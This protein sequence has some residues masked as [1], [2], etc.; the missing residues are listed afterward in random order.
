M[1][2]EGLQNWGTRGPFESIRAGKRMRRPLDNV[3]EVIL[4]EKILPALTAGDKFQKMLQGDCMSVHDCM[5]VFEMALDNDPLTNGDSIQYQSHLKTTHPLANDL[6]NPHLQG[7]LFKVME[8]NWESLTDAEKASIARFRRDDP[9]WFH[10]Y[11]PV[12][13]SEEVRLDS[14]SKFDEHRKRKKQKAMS[15]SSPY[16]DLEFIQ[17]TSVQVERF[18]STC[19]R[20]MTASRRHMR[21]ELFD[22]IMTLHVNK[23]LWNVIDVQALLAAQTSNI[24][25][26]EGPDYGIGDW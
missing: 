12:E 9:A 7:S 11:P 2:G 14:P 26:E 20:V 22:A 10:V 19:G 4:A 23:D 1:G 25:A 6:L 16:I 17:G 5:E 8:G 24:D 3:E 15:S 18:F 13:N 21:P